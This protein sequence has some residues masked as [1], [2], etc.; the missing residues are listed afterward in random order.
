[1]NMS[2][3]ARS[4]WSPTCRRAHKLI[5]RI[6]SPFTQ[7]I[8]AFYRSLKII[9]VCSESITIAARFFWGSIS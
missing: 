5:K 2:I 4:S 8:P 7:S 9:N 3:F 6:W 1:L